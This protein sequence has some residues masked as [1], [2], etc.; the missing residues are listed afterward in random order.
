MGIFSNLF[1]GKKEANKVDKSYTIPTSGFRN[2]FKDLA[3][4]LDTT[5]P[6]VVYSKLEVFCGKCNAKFTQEVLE[7]LC[8]LG[9]GGM[10]SGARTVVLG[11]TDEGNLLRSGKC[12]SCGHTKMKIIVKT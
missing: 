1:G 2:L 7:M 3:K 12:P 4:S 5:N 8:T 6:D 11:A 10:F 9:P